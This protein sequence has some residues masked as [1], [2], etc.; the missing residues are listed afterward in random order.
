MRC[1]VAVSA[2]AD[3]S[4]ACGVRVLKGLRF[5]PVLTEHQTA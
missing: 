1:I 3:P 5:A 4:R 2:Y